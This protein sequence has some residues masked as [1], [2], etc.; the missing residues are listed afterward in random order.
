MSPP[1]RP[2]GATGLR[3]RPGGVNAL[4]RDCAVSPKHREHTRRYEEATQ[5]KHYHSS[6]Y[7]GPLYCLGCLSGFE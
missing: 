4:Q 1:V 3:Q 2:I 6:F 7:F 5:S